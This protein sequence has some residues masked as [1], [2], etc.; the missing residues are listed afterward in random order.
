[1]IRSANTFPQAA[2]IASS[3]SSFAAL[4]AA[5]IAY[6][7]SDLARAKAL[8]A[9]SDAASAPFRESLAQLSREGSGSSCRSFGGP[10]VSWENETVTPVASNLP[11]LSDLVVVVS[12]GKKEVGSSEAHRRVLT[13]PHWSGRVARAEA[14][15]HLLLPAIVRGDFSA[16]AELARADSDD[17]HD[18][19]ETSVP[20]FGYRTAATREV[21]DY[22][23]QVGS[24]YAVTLDAGPNVHVIVPQATESFWKQRLVAR[25][26]E[27]PLL[28]DRQGA[29]AEIMRIEGD[30][31]SG[32]SV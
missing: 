25:F 32:G 15:Y 11:P 22:L 16:F 17:M 13:S 27:H 31:A 29:G 19:F 7:S 4:T 6:F 23:P 26:P 28:V 30:P 24:P 9:A 14:R 10:F 3:A 8:I 20:S 18:L 1:M 5:S 12:G 2:G 21:I